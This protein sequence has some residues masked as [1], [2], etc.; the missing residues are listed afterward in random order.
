MFAFK[1]LS[2]FI[3]LFAINTCAAQSEPG[4]QANDFIRIHAPLIAI[5]HVRVNPLTHIGRAMNQCDALS[6]A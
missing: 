6:L 5:E 3:L 1:S 2:A 4:S